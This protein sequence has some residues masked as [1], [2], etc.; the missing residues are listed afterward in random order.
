MR[1]LFSNLFGSSSNGAEVA[2]LFSSLLSVSISPST[3]KKEIEEHPDFPSLLSISDILNNYGIEN[4]TAKFDPDKFKN[5]PTPFITQIKGDDNGNVFFSVVKEISATHAKFFDYEKKQWKETHIGNF[6]DQCTDIVL[7]GEPKEKSGEKNYQA[8]IKEEKRKK[9]GGYLALLCLPAVLLFTGVFSFIQN[10]MSALLPFLFS[11][12]MLTGTAVT[13]LLLWYEIDRY[14]PFL[15]QICSARK[16]ISCNAVL[17]SKGA[18]IFGI[19]WSTI[20]FCYFSGGL[21][22]LLIAGITNTSMLAFLSCLHLFTLPYIF[23]SIYYQWKVAKQWCVL[24]LY[25]QA[26]IA[27]TATITFWGAWHLNFPA[28]NNIPGLLLQ[29]TAGFSIPFIIATILP[30]SLKKAKESKQTKTELQRLKH[31]PQIFETLLQKQKAIDEEPYGLG[32]ILGNPSGSRK[33]IKVCNPYCEPC[34]NAHEPLEALLHNDPDLQLQIIFTASSAEGDYKMPPVRHLL[35][36]A[37]KG[38][39]E[40]TTQSLG[41]WYKQS[42]KNYDQ[43]ASKYPLNGELQRQKDKIDGM[44]N[45]CSKTKIQFTPTIFINGHQL[46]SL[47]TIHDLKYFLSV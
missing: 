30:P 24:C 44:S 45:W 36:I 1:Y 41:D 38:N 10:G 33:I 8:K 26:I 47:Y 34:A 31:N 21:I 9:Y 20:G 42:V 25:I 11:L 27:V 3:L 40:E 28:I 39:L 7:M 13:S 16:N 18:K 46:P 19:N 23:Y 32:I 6:T 35:A 37:E 5:I 22:S 15:Q 17:F 14:N 29:A 43:F 4:L 2:Y 12:L